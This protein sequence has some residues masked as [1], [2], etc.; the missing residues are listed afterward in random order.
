[1]RRERPGCEERIARAPKHTRVA[2]PAREFVQ[3]RGLADP[4]L[5]A[6]KRGAAA[7]RRGGTQPIRQFGQISFTLEQFHWSGAAAIVVAIYS[8]FRCC[9]A[10]LMRPLSC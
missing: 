3:Q 9:S 2:L 6:Q 1:M 4:C 10:A 8:A 7:A 5:A